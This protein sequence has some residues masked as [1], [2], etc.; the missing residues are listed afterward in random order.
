[1]RRPAG[2]DPR[3]RSLALGRSLLA[4]ATLSIL[5]FTPARALFVPTPDNPAGVRCGGARGLMLWCV[6]GQAPWLSTARLVVAIAVLTLVV[7]GYHPR[8]TCVPHWYVT[9]SLG[10]TMTIPNG[11]DEVA[12]IVALLLIP[13]C[14]GD[15]R[16]WHWRASPEPYPATWAGVSYAAHLVLRVQVALIYLSAVVAKLRVPSW[17]HGTYLAQVFDHPYYGPSAALR[18]ILEPALGSRPVVATLTWGTLALELAIAASMA[19]GPRIRRYGLVLGIALHGMIIVVMGLFSFGLVMIALLTLTLAGGGRTA[20]Y[21]VR[22][23]RR[24]PRSALMRLSS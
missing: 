6:G 15:H 21:R 5:V 13:M 4:S 16:R 23:S 7:I 10:T 8:W 2:F 12:R 3:D 22:P 17:R 24:S 9:A 14:L 20:D 19:G 1:L 11:G 18:S